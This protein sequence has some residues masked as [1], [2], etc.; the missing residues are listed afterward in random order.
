MLKIDPSSYVPIYE[1]IKK[2]IKLKIALGILEVNEPLPSIREMSSE[3]LLNP[4]T[5]A[6]A[7]RELEREGFIYTKKGIGCFISDRSSTLIKRERT[8]I[9]GGVFKEAIDIAKKYQ[10]KSH[11]IKKLFEK[12]LAEK[13]KS[14]SQGEEK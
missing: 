6:R 4:N 13:E 14:D 10:L 9:L 1:Q 2:E 5:I 7:Y 8:K 3:L 12:S 11:E